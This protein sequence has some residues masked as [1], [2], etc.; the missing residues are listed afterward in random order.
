VLGC[1]AVCAAVGLA[2]SSEGPA[3]VEDDGYLVTA[4]VEILTAGAAQR[5]IRVTCRGT[6]GATSVRGTPRATRGKAT[7]VYRPPLSAR[8]KTLRGTISFTVSGTRYV[9]HFSRQLS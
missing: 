4:S 6:L 5:P 3:A 7:C 2:A 1:I 9:R 8:G